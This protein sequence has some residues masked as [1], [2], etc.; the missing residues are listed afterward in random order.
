[1][2]EVLRSHI[3]PT[4]PG[5]IGRVSA[6]I[7]AVQRDSIGAVLTARIEDE[8]EVVLSCVIAARNEKGSWNEPDSASGFGVGDNDSPYAWFDAQP[9]TVELSRHYDMVANRDERW[10]GEFC[11]IEMLCPAGAIR[12]HAS[13]ALGAYDVEVSEIGIALLLSPVGGDVDVVVEY[14]DGRPFERLTVRILDSEQDALP[15]WE[16]PF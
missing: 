5:R 1:M 14:G 2:H 15:S 8:D 9:R 7:A 3:V 6:A 4:I 12:L 11:C 13:D 16:K 10:S